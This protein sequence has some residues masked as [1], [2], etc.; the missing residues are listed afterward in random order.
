M[1][2]IL[3]SYQ[4]RRTPSI[5]V[6]PLP[7]LFNWIFFTVMRTS[8]FV[9]V[10]FVLTHIVLSEPGSKLK[11]GYSQIVYGHR[12]K[13][14]T[15]SSFAPISFLDCVE[16]CLLRNRCLSVS[17]FKG[18]NYCEIKYEDK[19]TAT[20]SYQEQAGWVYSEK[21]HWPTELAGP[22]SQSNCSLNEKCQL[23]RYSNNGDPFHCVVSG[24]YEGWKEFNGHNYFRNK[25][26]LSQPDAMKTCRFCGAYLVEIDDGEEN[27]WVTTSLLKDVSCENQYDCTTWTGANDIQT[28]KEF[29]WGNSFVKVNYSNWSPENPDHRKIDGKLKE[30]VDMFYDG[31]WNDRPCDHLNAFICEKNHN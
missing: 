12:I 25:T 26:L 20:S 28:E 8:L 7:I 2:F 11:H 21:R 10:L 19:L 3:K 29:V 13:D 6:L 24:C 5:E 1:L 22:C 23:T 9:W 17:Y 16:E 14:K 15:I 4:F 18:A 31:Q 27:G 30:C